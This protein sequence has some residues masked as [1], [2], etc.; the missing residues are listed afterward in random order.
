MNILSLESVFFRYHKNMPFVLQNFSMQAKHNTITAILGNS[1]CGKTSLLRLIAGLERIEKGSIFLENTTVD[2][3]HFFV[4]PERREVG[5]VFQDYAL[6]PHMTVFQN[7]A[8]ALHG[9]SK[10][11]KKLKVFEFLDLVELNMFHTKYPHE[12]SGG[13]QQRVALARSLCATPKILLL[14]EPFSNLDATLRQ[15]IRLD[16]KNILKKSAIT[17]IFV[18]H[19]ED[20]ALFLADQTIRFK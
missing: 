8:Y 14:D 7:I 9:F 5:M 6:F 11:E 3:P 2:S 17:T 12:L 16:V 15:K 1:G 13:Q 4:E 18:T 20:D 19:D 10:Q